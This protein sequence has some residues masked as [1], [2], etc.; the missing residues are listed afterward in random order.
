MRATPHTSSPSR[1]KSA[2]EIAARL[3]ISDAE[4]GDHRAILQTIV[5]FR[6]SSA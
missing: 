4:I 3:S 1:L 2:V 5:A 6:T